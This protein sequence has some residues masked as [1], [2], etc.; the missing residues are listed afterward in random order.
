[1]IIIILLE[2]FNI[3]RFAIDEEHGYGHSVLRGDFE[4][5]CL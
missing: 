2:E 5:F 3:L 4:E 1:M